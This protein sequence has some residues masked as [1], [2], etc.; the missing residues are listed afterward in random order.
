MGYLALVT[1]DVNGMGPLEELENL[2]VES[3]VA[4]IMQML[5]NPKFGFGKNSRMILTAYSWGGW[6]ALICMALSEQLREI[7][8]G[9]LLMTPADGC[10]L[11]VF[12]DVLLHLESM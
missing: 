4:T 2:K 1:K 9:M 10:F 6:L 5:L 7:V 11:P 8:G 12:Q 3:L